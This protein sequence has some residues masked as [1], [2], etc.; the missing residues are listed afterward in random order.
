ML[1]AEIGE[2]AYYKSENADEHVDASQGDAGK[3][4]KSTV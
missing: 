1:R 2:F 4:Q 3:R